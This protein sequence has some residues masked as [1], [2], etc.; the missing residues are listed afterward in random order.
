VACCRM[1]FTFTFTC[2]RLSSITLAI[3]TALRTV[4]RRWRGAELSSYLKY[5]V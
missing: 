4:S 1:N 2:T 3:A 5:L